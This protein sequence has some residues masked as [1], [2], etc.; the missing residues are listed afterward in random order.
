MKFKFVI[1]IYELHGEIMPHLY[2]THI[3]VKSFVLCHTMVLLYLM[4]QTP[5][6]FVLISVTRTLLICTMLLDGGIEFLLY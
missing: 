5:A 1:S 2:D 6:Q 3:C 4:K